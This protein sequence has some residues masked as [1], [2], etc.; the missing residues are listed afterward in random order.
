MLNK[1]FISYAREDYQYAKDI[2]E[3]LEANNFKPWMDKKKLIVGQ[4]WENQ[5]MSELKTADFIII[6]L[7]KTSVAKR[8]F[9]QREF[10]YA[11]KYAE[12]KLNSDIFILPIKLDDCEVPEELAIFNWA[13]YNE[14]E[15]YIEI[16]DALNIQRNIRISTIPKELINLNNYSEQKVI[17]E[18]SINSIFQYDIRYPIFHNTTSIDTEMLNIAIKN[19]INEHISF[20]HQTV[21][22]GQD[23]YTIERLKDQKFIYEISYSVGLVTN[24]YVSLM[25]YEF[26]D[27]WGAHPNHSWTSINV[28]FNKNKILTYSNFNNLNK[29]KELLLEYNFNSEE[30]DEEFDSPLLN[31]IESF[32]EYSDENYFYPKRFEYLLLDDENIL[33]N[34]SNHLP[35]VSK[36]IGQF[37]LKYKIENG[38]ISI[39]SY[40]Q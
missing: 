37:D 25:F 35:H 16:V 27:Y 1:V 28:A 32:T 31:N 10:K 19:Y 2:Y 13:E 8:G 15:T 18:G 4:R 29:L 38:N 3:F 12:E 24:E 14:Y 36:F 23:E 39:I 7:S 21:D 11:L 34:F 9:V 26:T 20:I 33:I 5:I 30:R 40:E 17:L 22:E 6:L